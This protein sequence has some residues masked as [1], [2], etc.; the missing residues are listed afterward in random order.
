MDHFAPPLL[1]HSRSITLL[2]LPSNHRTQD[3]PCVPEE[4]DFSPNL[5]VDDILYITLYFLRMCVYMCVCVR[6]RVEFLFLSLYI[7]Y[8]IKYISLQTTLD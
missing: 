7:I 3:G 6:V 5:P 2:Y 1:S 8:F 4:Q